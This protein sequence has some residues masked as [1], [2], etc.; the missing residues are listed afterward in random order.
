MT[1]DQLAAVS[2][3]PAHS[4]PSPFIS[5]DR[6]SENSMLCTYNP[7]KTPTLKR[8]KKKKKKKARK[9]KKETSDRQF[10]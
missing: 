5:K 1:P 10:M 4:F 3:L 2:G 6:D 7:P 9:K 8:Q